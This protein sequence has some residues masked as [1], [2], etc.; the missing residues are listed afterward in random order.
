MNATAVN[1]PEF[2]GLGIGLGIGLFIGFVIIYFIPTIIAVFRKHKNTAAIFVV[3]LFLGMTFF[4]WVFA[5]A[6]SV[7]NYNK[8]EYKNESSD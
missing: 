2:L 7:L 1:H 6:W 5:L 8:N 4:G 3:N